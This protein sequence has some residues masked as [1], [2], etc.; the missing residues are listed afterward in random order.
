MT[1]QELLQIIQQENPD[2]NPNADFGSGDSYD[3]MAW[4][5]AQQSPEIRLPDGRSL[6][7]DANGTIT[8]SNINDARTMQDIQRLTP[9]GG[10]TNEQQG[11]DRNSN[12]QRSLAGALGVGVA[13]PL[14]GAAAAGLLGGGGAAA[15]GLTPAQMAAVGGSEAAAQAGSAALAGGAAGGV[16]AVAPVVGGA[17]GASVLGG[18]GSAL[19]SNPAAVGA[20]LGG[21]AGLAGS[22][23]ETQTQQSGLPSWMQPYAEQYLQRANQESMRPFTPYA[24]EGV[25]PMNA[26]QVMGMDQARHLAGVGDPLVSR[27]RDQQSAV[28]SG[29]MLGANPFLDRVAQG[30]GDRMGEA[31]ATGTRGQITGAAINSG[32][33]PRF[34]SA[35]QQTVGNADRAFG[36]ALGQTM[37]GLYYGNFRDERAAQDAAARGSLGFSQDQR[38]NTTGLLNAGNM[39]QQ[40]R[41]LENNYARGEFDRQL[42]FPQQ[43]LG[44]LGQAI[45]PAFGQQQQTTIPGANPFQSAIGGALS[46]WAIGNQFASPNQ[47]RPPQQQAPSA[48]PLTFNGFGQ[49]SGQSYGGNGTFPSFQMPGFAGF[50]PSSVDH[51]LRMPS[52][53]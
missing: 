23:D 51:S 1:Y 45:N 36:D 24:G 11:Y 3:F 26:D 46:G 37:S 2:W 39:Q 10:V 22:G 35:Y 15:G 33:S 43:Q 27:A 40:Q 25:A 49:G 28:L 41:Q 12:W 9:D 16:G 29:Q 32:N 30:I 34:S 48:A 17:G 53:Y 42:A 14:A 13:A 31:Y 44:L 4:Q 5:R 38:A 8:V 18:M 20:L 50:G 52:F 7:M 19:A 47:Q 6:N 21:A